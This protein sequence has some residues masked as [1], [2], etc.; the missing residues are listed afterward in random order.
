[1]RQAVELM[2]VNDEVAFAIRSDVN[3]AFDQF[4]AAKVK[5][6][7]FFHELVVIAGDENDLG[8]LAAFAKEFLDQDVVIVRP[9]PFA[10]QLPAVNEIAD[11]VEV[12]ALRI[13]EK[14]EQ[15]VHLEMFHSEMQ[16]RNPYRA[17]VHKS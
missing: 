16:I 15:F 9:I 14:V 8:A 10:A 13:A 1:M 6:V 12:V 2:A 11:D 4:D 5:A 7:K 17:V 3:G